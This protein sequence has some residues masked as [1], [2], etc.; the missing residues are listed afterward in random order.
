MVRTREDVLKEIA[1]ANDW[2]RKP[3][4]WNWDLDGADLSGL[5]LQDVNLSGTYLRGANLEGADLRDANLFGAALQNARLVNA[6]LSC[7]ELERASLAGADLTGADFTQAWLRFASFSAEQFLDA[8]GINPH[9]T[10]GLHG[11]PRGF[12]AALLPDKLTRRLLYVQ[13]WN[14]SWTLREAIAATEQLLPEDGPTRKLL[15]E[16]LGDWEGTAEEAVATAKLLRSA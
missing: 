10:L 16:L 3:R 13:S 15:F 2:G 4:F 14:Y 7:A 9:P 11:A 12:W 8:R 5:F 6:E 1:K